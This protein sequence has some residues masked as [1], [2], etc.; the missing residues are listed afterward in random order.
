MEPA[1]VARRP[2]RVWSLIRPTVEVTLFFYILFYQF[3]MI[4]V[5]S[6]LMYSLCL[7]QYANNTTAAVHLF[8]A[9]TSPASSFHPPPRSF[10]AI[11]PEALFDQPPQ[12]FPPSPHQNFPKSPHSFRFFPPPIHFGPSDVPTW[13]HE[14]CFEISAHRDNESS[15]VHEGL[16][17]RTSLR[18]FYANSFMYVP[19]FFFAAM[20]GAW[21]DL[22]SRKL[23]LLVPA[24]GNA[25]GVALCL[26]LA[27]Y[28]PDRFHLLLFSSHFNLH[29]LIL[30]HNRKLNGIFV[31][32]FCWVNLAL[33]PVDNFPI[34]GT[35]SW[36][37][38]RDVKFARKF[39]SSIS[40]ISSNI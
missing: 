23:A 31:K 2:R 13:L 9:P 37:M 34:E 3:N 15:H 21:G 38:S 14:F 35:K 7:Q 36:T 10:R 5:Q 33:G 11:V 8:E 4:T 32:H 18:L 39:F 20:L 16:S 30:W 26:G 12:I 25:I 24:A 22:Y 19:A 27:Y 6:F 29:L 17:A 40:S 1:V 28:A